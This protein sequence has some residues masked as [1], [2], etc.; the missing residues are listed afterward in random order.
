MKKV[1]KFIKIATITLLLIL[2]SNCSNE[3]YEKRLKKVEDRVAELERKDSAAF[4][5][6]WNLEIKAPPIAESAI[7][8]ATK[9]EGY[10]CVNSNVGIFL[11]TLNAVEPY[12]DGYKVKI[13]LGNPSYITYDGA[14][15]NVIWG[16][17]FRIKEI[18]LVKELKAGY[19]NPVEFIISPAKTE[20]TKYIEISIS[21][22]Q[23]SL[24]K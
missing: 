3:N 20:D 21:V 15:L 5:R 2:I 6:I 11:I 10:I 24:F 17:H 8:D 19:W 16:K 12:L 14:K 22:S 9:S 4:D 7:F 18:N 23:L 1:F 13:N